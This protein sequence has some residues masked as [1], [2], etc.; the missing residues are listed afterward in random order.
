MKNQT[1]RPPISCVTQC[2]HMRVIL[3]LGLLS[4]LVQLGHG[5]V[6]MTPVSYTG[7]ACPPGT[8]SFTGLNPENTTI[9][10]QTG[11]DFYVGVWKASSS[12]TF[13]FTAESNDTTTSLV[14]RIS[15]YSLFRNARATCRNPPSVTTSVYVNTNN[16]IIQTNNIGSFL[17]QFSVPSYHFL[18]VQNG[19]NTIRIIIQLTWNGDTNCAS[20]R[21]Q[22]VF[23]TTSSATKTSMTVIVMMVVFVVCV[24][25]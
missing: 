23:F 2:T 22:E 13:I 25:F 10:A 24:L 20:R 5:V 17:Y 1:D 19:T 6:T 16:P 18:N 11:G 21:V 9:T 3:F 15:G 7:D 14:T 12:C 8:I 4:M